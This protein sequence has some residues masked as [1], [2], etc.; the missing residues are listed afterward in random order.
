MKLKSLILASA[1]CF[2]STTFL[3]AKTRTFTIDKPVMIGNY[4]VPAG[5]YRMRVHGSTAEITDMNHFV[6][7]KP[8]KVTAVT[9]TGGDKFNKTVVKTVNDGTNDRVTEIDLSHSREMV[10][11]NQ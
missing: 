4:T 2:G 8:V 11:F 7:R 3:S 1:L 5:T 10:Q 6:D 9:S